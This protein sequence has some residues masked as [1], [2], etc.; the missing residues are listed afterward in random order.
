[1]S[2][3]MVVV[4]AVFSAL[5]IYGL[6]GQLESDVSVMRYLAFSLAVIAAGVYRLTMRKKQ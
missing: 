2:A 5:W 1:M 3:G 4:L 6:L